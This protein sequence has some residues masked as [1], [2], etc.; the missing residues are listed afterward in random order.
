MDVAEAYLVSI[1][2]IIDNIDFEKGDNSPEILLPLM[3]KFYSSM[4][5]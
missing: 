5:E 3:K 2:M 1:L 4:G